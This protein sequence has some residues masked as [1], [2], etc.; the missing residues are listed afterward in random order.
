[1]T[2]YEDMFG[3]SSNVG[4]PYGVAKVAF[5]GK[6]GLE[7][8]IQKG[9]VQVKSDGGRE[10]Y[11]WSEVKWGKRTGRKVQTTA[12]AKSDVQKEVFAS[13]HGILAKFKWNFTLSDADQRAIKDTERPLRAQ[14]FVTYSW[15]FAPMCRAI[16]ASHQ[17]KRTHCATTNTNHVGASATSFWPHMA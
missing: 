1:M 4:K 16:P 15:G 13:L 14:V 2:R 3:E 8:A 5:G 10:Y 12:S 6:E 11:T 7:E 9:D 17:T